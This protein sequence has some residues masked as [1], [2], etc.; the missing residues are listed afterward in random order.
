MNIFNFK[1]ATAA[2]LGVFLV[3][4]SACKPK[5]EVAVTTSSSTTDSS[6]SSS[7]SSSTSSSSSSSAGSL[8]LNGKWFS[9]C[10]NMGGGTYGRLYE[11][12]NNLTFDVVAYIYGSD[13]SCTGSVVST[14]TL[15]SGLTITQK[16]LTGVASNFGVYDLPGGDVVVVYQPFSWAI[17]SYT[18]S[19]AD[20]PV[21]TTWASWLSANSGLNSF[22]AHPYNEATAAYHFY[23]IDVTPPTTSLTAAWDGKY[24][25]TFC[26]NLNGQGTMYANLA[27]YLNNG[28]GRS[29]IKN[30]GTDATCTGTYTLIEM[31]NGNPYYEYSIPGVI[32]PLTNVAGIPAGFVIMEEKELDGSGT[33]YTIMHREDANHIQVLTD[34]TTVHQGANWSDWTSGVSD[35]AGFATSPSNVALPC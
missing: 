34:S 4:M 26:I 11:N 13:E 18:I 24:E 14:T 29:V 16:A 6:T 2:A 30:Y 17:H 3:S 19:S 12:I 9:Q 28:I 21:G 5:V 33:R 32:K 15:V 27:F 20:V 35:I 7:S 1:Y 8:S 23:Q 22:A 25:T 10:W 31:D